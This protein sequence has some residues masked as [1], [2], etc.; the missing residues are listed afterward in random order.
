LINS[1]KFSEKI[2]LAGVYFEDQ[3]I[4]LLAGE[5]AVDIN[6]FQLLNNEIANY[7]VPSLELLL[8]RD[9]KATFFGTIIS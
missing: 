7:A 2:R 5:L 1:N 3:K 6:M 4:A 8:I 9:R